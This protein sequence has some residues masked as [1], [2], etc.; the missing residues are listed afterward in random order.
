MPRRIVHG[1]CNSKAM[2][3][4]S[5]GEVREK[6]RSDVCRNF[7]NVLRP[8]GIGGVAKHSAVATSNGD[9]RFHFRP[10][11]CRERCASRRLPAPTSGTVKGR[12]TLREA[13]GGA[14]SHVPNRNYPKVGWGITDRKSVSRVTMRPHNARGLRSITSNGSN[15]KDLHIRFQ[16]SRGRAPLHMWTASCC[17]RRTH[18]L[19]SDWLGRSSQTLV[20]VLLDQSRLSP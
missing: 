3:V 5:E 4:E 13:P 16:K 10:A 18:L 1:A 7:G 20:V 15:R 8:R 19:R 9:S 17:A 12:A 6:D 11:G 14:R 2:R